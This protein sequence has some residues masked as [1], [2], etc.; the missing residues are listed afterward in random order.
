MFIS[1]KKAAKMIGV[2]P[3]TMRRWVD[4]GHFRHFRT[5][6]GHRRV[7]LGDLK[8][9]TIEHGFVAVPEILEVQDTADTADNTADTVDTSEQTCL[10]DFLQGTQNPDPLGLEDL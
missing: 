2:V 1:L 9:W 5:L 4:A 10:L 8:R 6:G 7:H 3:G